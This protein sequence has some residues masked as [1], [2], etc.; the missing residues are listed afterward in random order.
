M[1]RHPA[2]ET[3]LR[4]FHVQGFSRR[5]MARL[6]NLSPST[7]AKPLTQLGLSAPVDP[8]PHGSPTRRP[9]GHPEVPAPMRNDLRELIDWWRARRAALQPSPEASRTTACVTFQVARRWLEAI[10]R[11]A[12][13]DGTT[14]SQVVPQA[15]QAFCAAKQA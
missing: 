10:R 3:Q 13:L 12:A 9:H 6:L 8:P 1:A 15:F 5:T 4:D 2:Y 14:V 7:V 11:H